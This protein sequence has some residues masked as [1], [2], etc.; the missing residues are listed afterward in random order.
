MQE[1]ESIL[2]EEL[3]RTPQEDQIFYLLGNIQ[4]KKSNW[5]EAL[6]YYAQAIEIN[7]DSPATHARE[8][9]V[10]IL[11]FYDKDRYNV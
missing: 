6:Q 5:Q 8:M 2:L 4:R 11:N 9:I 7:P 3:K 10:Q 1:A